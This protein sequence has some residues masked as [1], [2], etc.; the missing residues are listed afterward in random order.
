MVVTKSPSQDTKL[1]D[2]Y[3]S[4][5]NINFHL[6]TNKQDLNTWINYYLTKEYT[7]SF[8]YQVL[9]TDEVVLYGEIPIFNEKVE[10]KLTFEPVVLENGDL[11]LQQKTISIGKLTLP[12]TFVLKFIQSSYSVPDWVTIQ[13]NEKKVY[14]KLQNMKLK[15]ELKVSV[16]E[17]DLNNNDIEFLLQVPIE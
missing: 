6:K 17:F 14:M 8:E 16:Q 12:V 9:L 13:P 11:E 10:M 4:Q 7:G 1:P 3:H 5:S 2:T 15:S